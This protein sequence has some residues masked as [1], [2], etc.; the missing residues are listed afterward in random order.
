MHNSL[1]IITW[2]TYVAVKKETA[3]H[4]TH[5]A[6]M[7]RQVRSDRAARCPMKKTW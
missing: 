2:R 4:Q 7:E 3:H 6:N 1:A 5:T